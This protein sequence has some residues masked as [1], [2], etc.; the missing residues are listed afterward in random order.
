[1]RPALHALPLVI[2]L[3]CSSTSTDASND[4]GGGGGGGGNGD[5]S[6]TAPFVPSGT[7]ATPSS[8]N[9]SPPPAPAPPPEAK[10]TEVVHVVI[11]G[12]G[13]CTGTLISKTM[14]VTAAHCLDPK[15]ARSWDVI[16]PLSDGKT[17]SH[18]SRVIMYD[19]DYEDVAKPDFG[20]I[21]LAEPIALA[22]YAELTD[23]SGMVKDDK[24]VVAAI[25]VRKYIAVDAPFTLLEGL[26]TS[27]AEKYGYE[28]GIVTKIF[29]EGGDSGAGL[30]LTANGKKT[31]KLI[32]V[33]RQPEPDRGVDH[34]TRIDADVINWVHSL[35]SNGNGT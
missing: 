28:H 33:A 27:S 7:G 4:G 10:I 21:I 35:G 6:P 3:G 8:G 23:V 17:K 19:G 26:E 34:F 16:A 22:A 30:F 13:L 18:A 9:G 2:L 15:N 14:V 24:T 11:D 12:R 31:H 20:V 1:M 25:M 29:S 32:G 5:G